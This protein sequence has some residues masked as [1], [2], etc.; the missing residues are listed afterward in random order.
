MSTISRV[1]EG[2]MPLL[3]KAKHV[4]QFDLLESLENRV[5]EVHKNLKGFNGL[6]DIVEYRSHIPQYLAEIQVISELLIFRLSMHM[7][8]YGELLEIMTTN[9][10]EQLP[11]EEKYTTDDNY[12]ELDF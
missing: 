7:G 9:Y 8:E 10:I 2:L 5:L 12:D 3:D 4:N 6:E 1:R 11:E